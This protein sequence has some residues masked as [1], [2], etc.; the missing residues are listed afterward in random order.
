MRD[1][2]HDLD[3]ALAHLNDGMP[4]MVDALARLIA[5][6]TSF[7]PG[8]GYGPFADTTEDLFAPLGFDFERIEVPETLWQTGT[9][10]VH[11]A[12]INLIARRKTGRPVCSLYFHT[13]VVPAGD[14]W[15]RPPFEL[16]QED[17]RLFGRGA[18]DMKGTIASVY[19][20]LAAARKTGLDLAYD[21][22]LLFCTDEEGGLYP[23]IRHLAEIGAVEGH[24]LSFN[25]QA[26]PRI[27]AG[28]FGSLD[29]AID[30][31][32]RSA[33]SGD[34]VGGVNAVEEAL[35]LLD[36]LMTLKR[37][38]ETRTS[39][40]TPPPHFPPGV[41]LKARLT[42]AAINAGSKGSALPGHCRIVV[43]RRYTPDE[44]GAEVE[45]E[46]RDTIAA[47]LD[48]GG[49]LGWKATVVG[50]LAPV[51]DPVGPHWPRWQAALSEGFGYD[52]EDFICYGASSSSDMGWVQ[53]AG[54]REIL[55]GGLSRPDNNGHA[56]DEFTTT[57]NLKALAHAVLAYL[58]Q[59][60]RSDLLTD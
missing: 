24:L 45:A 9:G 30:I 10:D 31:T 8:D 49:A 29:L 41:P 4:A 55:L 44:D 20:A 47:A 52:P 5:V 21:P 34:P 37:S 33:H 28:C 19:G 7:P 13:D 27:W 15:T 39:E 3:L 50:H 46:L 53:Q 17:D 1:G 35:P 16:T 60:F 25:G 32:G 11:G 56:A 18:S 48:G 14:G 12:R 22:I 42:I 51:K 43:N 59:P 40:M 57:G 26:S 54:I 23:G 58:A 38:V 36:R 6:D 2:G